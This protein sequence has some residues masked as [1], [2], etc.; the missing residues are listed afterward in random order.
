MRNFIQPGET[1]TVVAPADV[2]SGALVVV[3]SII[4]VAAF[5]AAS[6]A[7]LEIATEGVFALPKATTDVVTQGVKLY[8]DSVASKL[9]VTPG[10][11]SKPL[12]GLA[13]SGAGNGATTVNCRL[14]L[15]GQTGPS[16]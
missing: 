5:D 16:A 8:W 4:G 11:N 3:G 1:L 13:A 12:V 14:M 10:T 9:T 7:D 2:T 6:G 15:T